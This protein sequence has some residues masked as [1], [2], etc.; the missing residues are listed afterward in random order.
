MPPPHLTVEET[1]AL[2]RPVVERAQGHLCSEHAPC[3]RLGLGS[4]ARAAPL[5]AELDA[6]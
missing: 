6:H 1:E 2:W 3:A 4:R 5:G